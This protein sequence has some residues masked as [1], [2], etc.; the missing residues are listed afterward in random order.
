MLHTFALLM[1]NS[2]NRW[3][4]HKSFFS[5]N[6][7]MNIF[8]FLDILWLKMIKRTKLCKMKINNGKKK[9]TIFK[10]TFFFFHF[11][12][13]CLLAALKAQFGEDHFEM[14]YLKCIAFNLIFILFF[15][16]TEQCSSIYILLLSSTSQLVINIGSVCFVTLCLQF[17]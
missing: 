13:R 9:K 15:I 1:I 14:F 5:R 12:K 16:L 8:L 11:N 2:P 3:F 17:N 7:Q 6:N 10:W 4:C